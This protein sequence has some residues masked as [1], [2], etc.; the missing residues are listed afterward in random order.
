MRKNNVGNFE[1]SLKGK[2][3]S[4]PSFHWGHNQ[5]GKALLDCVDCSRR[6]YSK[7]EAWFTED[8]LELRFQACLGYPILLHRVK[9]F[10]L[11]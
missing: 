5:D 2:D 6:L 8:L 9:F 1:G 7:R 4:F 10:Y 3:I 11:N